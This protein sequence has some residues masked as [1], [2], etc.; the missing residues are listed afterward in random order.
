MLRVTINNPAQQRTLM[1]KYAQTQAT[2]YAG[3]LDPNWP[4]TYDIY[5][6]S[7][8]KLLHDEVFTLWDGNGQPFGLSSLFVAPSLGID[9]VLATGGNEFTVWQLDP[10]GL[11]EVLAPAFDQ[12]ATWASPQHGGVHV[13]DPHQ[14]SS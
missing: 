2:A 11:F 4:R 6:G 12:Q 8:M 3:F 9:E 5:P 14:R 13:Q 1:P 10:Q 7:V